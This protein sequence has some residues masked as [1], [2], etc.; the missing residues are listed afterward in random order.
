MTGIGIGVG[1]GPTSNGGGGASA[2]P[3]GAL[4]STQVFLDTDFDSDIDDVLDLQLLL[5]LEARG[6]CRIVGLVN[7]SA[8]TDS[9]GA[10]YG[11]LNFFNR[12]AIPM[13]A[14]SAALGNSTSLFTTQLKAAWGVAGHSVPGDFTAGVTQYRTVLAGIAGKCIIVTTGGLE[15]LDALLN[16][17]GDGISALNGVALVLAKV[18]RIYMVAGHWPSGAAV[19]DMNSSRVAGADIFA[20]CPVPL[21]AV[22]VD[23]DDVQ[24]SGDGGTITNQPRDEPARIAWV[25]FFG[26]ELSTNGRG[27]CAQMALLAAVR[28]EAGLFTRPGDNGQLTVNTTTGGTLWNA[29]PNQLQ[30]YAGLSL[31]VAS[32]PALVNGLL[33]GAAHASRPNLLTNGDFA[34]NDLTGW[35]DDHTGS[36][37]ASGATGAGVLVG[38]SSTNRGRIS[39]AFAC[40]IGRKYN[41]VLTETGSNYN[42]AIEITKNA[43]DGPI[44]QGPLTAATS[45]PKVIQFTATAATHRLRI[46]NI[47]GGGTCTFDNIAI[48]EA[49]Q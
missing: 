18:S 7:S 39:Q 26:N 32:W 9:A 10:I 36:G 47:A 17:A 42:L 22:D 1:V 20:L 2:L 24:V 3:P 5:N 38:S 30:G 40:T 8:N 43:S 41:V 11:M 31:P 29:A 21:I 49:V 13:G 14:N 37:T 35:D 6:E 16:S 23:I 48:Y 25:N 44:T 19:S 15:T 45:A 46:E 28:G 4:V 27:F 33:S 12:A 34:T